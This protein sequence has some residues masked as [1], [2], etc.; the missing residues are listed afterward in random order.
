MP[1]TIWFIPAAARFL[2]PSH[3]NFGRLTAVMV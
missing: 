3:L 1:D 2:Q